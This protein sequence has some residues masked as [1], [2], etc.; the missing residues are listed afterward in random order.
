[1]HGRNFPLTILK[2]AR[3]REELKIVADQEG[4]PTWARVVADAT[5]EIVSMLIDDSDNLN[6]D[7]MKDVAGIYHMCCSGQTT[8]HGL[9]SRVIELAGADYATRL[10]PVSSKEYGSPAARPQNSALS[11][12]KLSDTFGVRLPPWDKTLE[13]FM[14]EWAHDARYA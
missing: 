11:N 5:M 14:R 9:A 4:S 1:M 13:K 2:L 12:K 10:A 7:A 8:W 3:N 6:R